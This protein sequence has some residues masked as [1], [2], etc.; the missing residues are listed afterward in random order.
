MNLGKKKTKSNA[1]AANPANLLPAPAGRG[2]AQGRRA[3]KRRARFGMMEAPVAYGT[4]LQRSVPRMLPMSG[5]DGRIRVSHREYLSEVVG[6]T[7]F[8]SRK[9]ALNPGMVSSFPWL[10]GIAK[11]YESY[12]FRSLQFDYVTSVGTS[13]SGT[14]MM[15]VDYD[16]YDPKPVSKGEM[17]QQHNSQRTQVW[18]NASLRCDTA[19]L[20]KFGTQRYTRRDELADNL[21]V[22]TY[23]VGALMLATEGI[24]AAMLELPVGELFVTY[25]VDLMTP[26]SHAWDWTP[27]QLSSK[28]DGANGVSDYKPLGTEPVKV[29]GI[30]IVPLNGDTLRFEE[31]GDYRVEFR[32]SGTS[33]NN[34]IP[35]V[36]F[37]LDCLY[38]WTDAVINAAATAAFSALALHIT[39]PG[40]LRF[41]YEG[42]AASISAFSLMSSIFDYAYH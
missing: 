31:P 13:T 9:I 5:S 3:R 30:R 16:A 36:N 7:A 37:P 42:K 22:K 6:S 33:I 11:L 19:D 29:G 40:D 23:D 25:V 21:D 41:S 35:V 34:A 27:A 15:A 18:S 32:T 14:V 10:S 1:T 2:Q 17:L 8:S 39:K 28:I 24:P 20:Q 26:Q 38:N 12:L 4:A